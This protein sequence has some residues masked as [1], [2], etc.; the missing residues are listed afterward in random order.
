MDK[1]GFVE[2]GQG[3]PE[4]YVCAAR[5]LNPAF[6]GIF[7][8]ALWELGRSV[9]RPTKPRCS[10]CAYEQAC[11]YARSEAPSTGP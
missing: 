8:L 1:L 7:D 5:D 6:P 9:C 2:E 10:Q 11:S 4:I 3:K